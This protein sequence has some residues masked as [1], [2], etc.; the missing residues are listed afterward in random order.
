MMIDS[1][2]INRGPQDVL[3]LVAE[4]HRIREELEGHAKRLYARAR[5]IEQQIDDIHTSRRPAMP[6]PTQR[7]GIH[8]ALDEIRKGTVPESHHGDPCVPGGEEPGYAVVV[9]GHR[10][11]LSV[12]HSSPYSQARRGT[13][14]WHFTADEIATI[15]AI[16]TGEGF[17]VTK[18]WKHD[19]GLSVEVSREDLS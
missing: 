15:L 19:E 14:L 12:K 7:D 16:I 11:W 18:H 10:G 17:T 13:K 3:D 6:T 2:F 4:H 1:L 8:A 9:D 5:E